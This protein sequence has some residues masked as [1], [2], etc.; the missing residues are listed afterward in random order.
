MAWLLV[1]GTRRRF[2]ARHRARSRRGAWPCRRRPPSGGPAD[3]RNAEPEAAQRVVNAV[4]P[5]GG[6]LRV[7]C[8]RSVTVVGPISRVESYG[9]AGASG[10]SRDDA[11]STTIT[12][13]RN[14]RRG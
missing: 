6:P 9:P 8:P 3:G 5:N 14:A 4:E 13:D 11:A 2:T 10:A 12:N 7:T 1:I